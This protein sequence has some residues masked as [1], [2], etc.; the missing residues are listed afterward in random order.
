MK[1]KI[2]EERQKNEDEKNKL[3]KELAASKILT[4]EIKINYENK[5][6]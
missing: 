4:N 2:I 1:T 3:K 6:T 5:L